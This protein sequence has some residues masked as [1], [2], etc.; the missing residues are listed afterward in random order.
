MIQ[1]HGAKLAVTPTSVDI[2]PDPLETAL[3]GLDGPVI[4]ELDSIKDFSVT[5]GDEWDGAA[6]ILNRTSDNDAAA[7]ELRI[8]FLPGDTDGAEHVAQLIRAALSGDPDALA[9]TDG[10]GAAASALPAFD[11]VGLDVETANQNWGS[12]CQIGLAKV[13]DGAVTDTASWLCKPPAGIDRFD[14]ANV[15]IHGIS[16]DDVAEAP[17][18]ADRLTELKDFVGDLPIVAHNAYF[19]A[20]A[21]RSAAIASGV[22]IPQLSFGCTLA[23]SRSMDL[24][25]VNH[26]LPTVCE[27]VGVKL[28]KH[29]DAGA[30]AEACANLMVALARRAQHSGSLMEFVHAIGFSMGTIGTDRVTPA[31]KDRSGATIAMQARAAQATATGATGTVPAAEV[32]D[33]ASNPTTDEQNGTAAS[34]PK[35]DNKGSGRRGP[36]PWQAVATPDTVP[37]PALDADPNSPLYNQNVTLTGEFAPHDKGELWDAIAAQGGEIG[38]NVTKKTTLLV[39]GEWGSMTWKEKRARELVDK[40]QDI[41]IWTAEQL[42]EALGLS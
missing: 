14:D 10:G 28:S 32:D 33:A 42:L 36:A 30:D 21:L 12:I 34:P 22:E 17:A 9:A 35:R 8:R 26:K 7:S 41:Q 31:L 11:F 38:K 27:S 6:V 3:A 19:D 39:V 15:R 18:F 25:V 40:G 20:S 23:Q 16:A 4:I 29:H 24:D 37:E 5:P 1:A 13:V 2:H